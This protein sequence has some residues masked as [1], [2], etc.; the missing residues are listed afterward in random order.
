[1]DKDK[2]KNTSLEKFNEITQS[3]PYVIGGIII[4]AVGLVVDVLNLCEITNGTVFIIIAT[5][6][7][8]IGILALLISYFIARSQNQEIKMEN[9]NLKKEKEKFTKHEKELLNQNQ[10]LR[11]HINGGLEFKYNCVTISVKKS[12]DEYFYH[13][14]YEKTFKIIS[15]SVPTYFNAQFYANKHLIDREKAKEFYAANSINW[16]DLRVRAY[17][18]YKNPEEKKFT[19]ESRLLIENITDESNYIPFKIQYI[20]YKDNI[21]VN[22]EKGCEVKL[23]YCYNVPI[24]L[25]GSYINR[26]LS[27]DGEKAQVKFITDEDQDIEISIEG[28][29]DTGVPYTIQE[30]DYNIDLIHRNGDSIK[31]I[32]LVSA[33]FKKYRVKWDIEKLINDPVAVNTTDGADQL[34][35]TNI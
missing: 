29:N 22:L 14:L 21:K 4:T 8:I 35:L 15:D 11:K 17:I 28:L 6:S 16:A 24:N 34:G 33:P 9:E 32:D 26:T 13:F 20:T 5:V 7:T 19:K 12:K 10:L 27:S 31:T 3:M 18:S 2:N 1:M 25:W 23:K 30:T